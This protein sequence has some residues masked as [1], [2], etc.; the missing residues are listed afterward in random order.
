MLDWLVNN[1]EWV[2][3]GIGV[4]LVLGL[5]GFIASVVSKRLNL[6]KTAIQSKNPVT[7]LSLHNSKIRHVSVTGLKS[8]G[9]GV[10]AS[11]LEGETL[12]VDNVIAG[13]K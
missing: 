10:N 11:G 2:F 12:V 6:R 7:G 4:S 9:D 3:S 5:L 8:T 1:M 13:K